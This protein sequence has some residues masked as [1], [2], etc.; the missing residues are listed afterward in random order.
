MLFHSPRH[1]GPAC[2]QVRCGY[3]ALGCGAPEMRQR[4]VA[5]HHRDCSAAH[6]QLLR[7]RAPPCDP[8]LL[9]RW[10][11]ATQRGGRVF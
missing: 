9:V 7:D 4:G 6:K 1:H 3:S 5:A 8:A 11:P 10:G 2:M